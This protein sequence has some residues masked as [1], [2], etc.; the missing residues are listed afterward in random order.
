[1]G[2][3]CHKQNW[4]SNKVLR[5]ALSTFCLAAGSP[6]IALKVTDILYN[7]MLWF[8]L[9]RQG[10]PMIPVM[11]KT[12]EVRGT[13]WTPEW[14]AVRSP[15]SQVSYALTR[16]PIMT[17]SS[18]R[19]FQEVY[20]DAFTRVNSRLHW[21]MRSKGYLQFFMIY[22]VHSKVYDANF[23]KYTIGKLRGTWLVGDAYG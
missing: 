6:F 15:H 8:S 23:G 14:V 19:G 13:F 9:R 12:W 22:S 17:W 16:C 10:Y 4:R 3:Q 5:A 7:H 1:M 21:K 2:R 20:N 18:V 11:L